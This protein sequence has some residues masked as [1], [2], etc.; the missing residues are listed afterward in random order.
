[1][2]K[3]KSISLILSMLMILTM[4][5]IYPYQK[6]SAYDYLSR[7]ID[8]SA[9][10]KSI[11]WDAVANDG[12]DFAIIRAGY[13]NANAYP[14]QKDKYFDYNLTNAKRV[15]IKCG[16][17]WFCYAT[18]VEAAYEEADSCY[19]IIKGIDLE[20][21][22]YLDVEDEK[23]HVL[24]NAFGNNKAKITEMAL[25]FCNRL[26][27]YGIRVGVYANR[28]WFTNYIDKAQIENS[29]YE[30]WLAQ[31]PSG[32]YAVTPDNYDKSSECGIWQY[33]SKGSVAGINGYVDVDVAYKEY[34]RKDSTP[35]IENAR[36]SK[37]TNSGYVVQ[38]EV[39]DEINPVT[40]VAFPTWTTK[41]DQDD[42]VWADGTISG[43]TATFE[44][45]IS[46]HNNELGFYRTHI[47][48]YNTTGAYSSTNVADVMIEQTPP[49]I[50]NIKIVNQTAKSY[51]VECE[52][53]DSGSGIDRVQ[54]P[55]WTE[56]N[57]QD[58]LMLDWGSNEKAR[59][60]IKGN[61]VT[62]TVNISDHNNESGIY[63]T[64]I[65]AYDK[66]GN[67]VSKGITIDFKWNE[68]VDPADLGDTLDAIILAKEPWIPIRV[69]NDANV[70]LHKEEGLSSEMWRFTKQSDGSYTIQNFKTGN[71][72][73]AEELGTVNGT[74]VVTS[75]ENGR[76][77]QRWFLYKLDDG[78]VIRAAY[79]DMV[80]DVAGGVFESGT[81]IQLYEK[82][83]SSAQTFSLYGDDSYGNPKI[84]DTFITVTG[85]AATM[86]FNGY[87][88]DKYRIY[89]S[90]D[91]KTWKVIDTVESDSYT[92]SSLTPLTTY[93]YKIDY[94]NRFYTGTSEVLSITTGKS[95]VDGDC[96]ADGSFSIADV[97][98]LQNWLLGR[99]V[100][101]KDWRA[102]DLCKDER[103]DVFDLCLMR[104]L[105]IEEG[106]L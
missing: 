73:E 89:R 10:Q 83:G 53:E 42:I 87:Y 56:L 88:A 6:A 28:D 13:G 41:D 63:T 34:G 24:I 31:Y 1:M 47:Y 74:N 65:Y 46:D 15:G 9:Y 95:N 45:K 40:R 8:V 85:T 104:R 100:K 76:D 90:T 52:V 20:L 60:T 62:Y 17:Y 36:I 59:G 61:I 72:L 30:I 66:C 98:I 103:L 93:Y 97:V 58:D 102:A 33:S 80:L 99:D 35:R 12:I 92:D 18:S 101:L 75:E 86:S 19:N 2:I 96:N 22:V 91:K 67:Y 4:F 54:F 32:E 69:S 94:I 37:I 23:N 3:R 11:N 57:G 14:E 79:T 106:S 105:L 38:C 50:S 7:G 43:A 39:Y 64:H 51:T 25:A 82:N 81:N 26:S 71:F 16:V 78:Y 77:N 44:V 21:P 68:G 27:S 70:A 84:N 49:T 5:N 55:T 48:C 29:G